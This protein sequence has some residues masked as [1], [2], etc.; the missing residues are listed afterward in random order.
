[1]TSDVEALVAAMQ[2]EPWTD[3][4]EQLGLHLCR[5]EDVGLTATSSDVEIWQ[6]CQAEELI[7]I[8]N[9]RNENSSDSMETAI[10]TLNTPS[11]LPV[12]TIG[13]L[14]RFQK[15]RAYAERVIDRLL[16][17]SIDIDR[18]RGAGRLYLP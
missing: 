9:N 5:F 3:F 6:R 10:H 2:R 14:P 12:F 17:Y 18:V 7:L 15:S 11:S 16:V 4:W 8:T 1:M 13:S